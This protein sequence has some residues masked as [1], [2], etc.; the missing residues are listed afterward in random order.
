[1]LLGAAFG[2]GILTADRSSMSEAG[3]NTASVFAV[4]GLILLTVVSVY[5]W[6]RH[7][8]S[9]AKRRWARMLGAVDGEFSRQHVVV[10]GTDQGTPVCVRIDAEPINEPTATAKYLYALTM[11]FPVTGEADWSIVP[12]QGVDKSDSEHWKVMSTDSE[13]QHKFEEVGA[14]GLLSTCDGT[15]SLECNAKSGELTLKYPASNANY[16]PDA[17]SFRNELELLR[18]AVGL[19]NQNTHPI[20]APTSHPASNPGP[21]TR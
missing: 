12:D 13:L 10:R 5:W 21:R 8:L 4:I 18:K 2:I 7:V 1:M 11:A 15:A 3:S 14:T 17:E 19:W 16:C 6:Y 9:Q 20:S